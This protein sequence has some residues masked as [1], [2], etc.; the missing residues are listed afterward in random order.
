MW[1]YKIYKTDLWYWIYRKKYVGK[2][3]VVQYLNWHDLWTP[4]KIQAKTFYNQDDAVSGLSIMKH[5]DGKD[6]D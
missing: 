3:I 6:T 2:M 4:H 5:K 1:E